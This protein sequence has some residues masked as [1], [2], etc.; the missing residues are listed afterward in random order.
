M[1]I[2]DRAS[3]PGKFLVF[4]RCHSDSVVLVQVFLRIYYAAAM[5]VKANLGFGKDNYAGMA[6]K[7]MPVFPLTHMSCLMTYL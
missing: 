5:N 2:Q 3:G 1:A 7:G 4:W 6:D